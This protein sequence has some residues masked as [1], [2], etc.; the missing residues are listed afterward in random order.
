M[1]LAENYILKANTNEEIIL[2]HLTYAAA[3]LYNIG[4]YQRHNWSE[5]SGEDY[6]DWYK[7]KKI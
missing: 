4:N 2:G 3:R 7:Q 1:K 6:P 5:D